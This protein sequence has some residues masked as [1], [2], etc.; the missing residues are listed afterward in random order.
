MKGGQMGRQG[1]RGGASVGGK[2]GRW[3]QRR[4]R[5][6]LWGGIWGTPRCGGLGAGGSCPPPSPKPP[7][8]RYRLGGRGP[9]GG[10]ADRQEQPREEPARTHRGPFKAPP[11]R[12]TARRAERAG[13]SLKAATPG[14]RAAGPTSE[15]R[16]ILW[17]GEG[18]KKP[19]NTFNALFR[20]HHPARPTP[21]TPARRRAGP[22]SEGAGLRWLSATPL[23]EGWGPP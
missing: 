12:A 9:A 16:R 23:L 21:E 3:G 10:G 8:P 22:P 4:T 2:R 11:S 15:K 18:E 13:P 1:A 7:P 5:G 19:K 14:R 17:W 6:A 20:S